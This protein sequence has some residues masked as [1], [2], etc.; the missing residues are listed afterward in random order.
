MREKSLLHRKIPHNLHWYSALKEVECNFPDFN[1]RLHLMTSFQSVSMERR[2]KSNFI[3]EKADKYS[4]SQVIKLALTVISHDD[5][6]DP[7]HMLKRVLTL[8]L[9]PSSQKHI[10]LLLSWKI[11]IEG[12]FT[13]HLTSVPQNFQSHQKPGKPEILSQP[14]RA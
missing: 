13:K 8:S 2:V 6:M 9:W 5:S 11:I 12:H 14:R 4:L 10:G 7:W 1:W 3:I